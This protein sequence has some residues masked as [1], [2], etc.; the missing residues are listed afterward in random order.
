VEYDEHEHGG[1]VYNEI[2]LY[3]QHWNVTTYLRMEVSS[4]VATTDDSGQVLP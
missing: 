3:L 4:V 2:Y 1:M